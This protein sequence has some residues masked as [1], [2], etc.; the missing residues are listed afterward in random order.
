M[1]L[2]Y[3]HT[4]TW[5]LHVC[6]RA[7]VMVNRW[8]DGYSKQQHQQ[9]QSGA[10]RAS[11]QDTTSTFLEFLPLLARGF[12]LTLFPLLVFGLYNGDSDCVHLDRF[13]E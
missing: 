5:M 2:A 13:V 3:T 11:V 12:F 10:S 7:I 9:R 4:R 1:R 6:M 8:T